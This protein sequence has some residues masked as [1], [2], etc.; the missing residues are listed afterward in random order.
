M[1]SQL[2]ILET[3][4]DELK[5]RDIMVFQLTPKTILLSNG[6]ET[7][8]SSIETYR[9]LSISTDFKGVIL[10]GKDGGVKFKKPFTIPV[11][12]IFVLI[13][14]MPMRK[15]E[16]RSKKE[17]YWVIGLLENKYK[18]SGVRIK[19]LGASTRGK[20]SVL[21]LHLEASLGE[22]NPQVELKKY[23]L[24]IQFR[25]TYIG[26]TFAYSLCS[27]QK[28]KSHGAKATRSQG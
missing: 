24:K 21:V 1:R 27:R 16:I 17:G 15:S 19:N 11:D 4:S 8:L 9:S 25:R 14:G 22:R 7:T 5:V 2:Q 13:D 20:R 26:S 10:V 3:K 28:N 12:D 6:E 18:N 23:E